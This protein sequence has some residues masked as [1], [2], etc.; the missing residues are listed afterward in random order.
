M[1]TNSPIKCSTCSR[2]ILRI[3]AMATPTRWTSFGPRWRSTWAASVSPSDSSRIAALSTLLNLVAV[4]L[5]LIGVNPLFHNLGYAARVFGDQALDGVQ[6]C[7]IPLTRA[8][9]EDA[10]RT[11]QAHT[12]LSQITTQCAHFTQLN[13]AITAVTLA[14]AAIGDVIEDRAQHTKYQDENKQHAEDLLDH[15]SEPRLCVERDINHLFAQFGGERRI[16][17]ADAVTPTGVKTYRV[18]YQAG[19]PRQVIAA[20]RHARGF[21]RGCVDFHLIVHYHRYRQPAQAPLLLLGVADRTIQLEVACGLLA[22]V[23]WVRRQHGQ[24]GGRI[25]DLGAIG[26]QQRLPGSN[27][28]R[29]GRRSG[30]RLLR[31][32]AGC[33]R[34]IAQRAGDTLWRQAAG[35]LFV[36]RL[37][38]AQR[39]LIRVKHFRG[40]FH[41]AEIH[42]RRNFGLVATRAQYRLQDVVHALGEQAFH[43][44]AVIEL[45]AGHG[46]LGHFLNIRQQIALLVDHGDLGLVHFRHAAG[47][48]IDD[49][50][51]LTRFQAAPGIQLN[52]YR[53]AGFAL[54]THKHRTLRDGQVY[55]GRFN[56]IQAGNGTRQFTFQAAAI[57]GG[58]HKLA[59]AQALLLVENLKTDAIVF[60]CNA[61]RS[62]AH[63]GARQVA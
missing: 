14:F 26:I 15:I 35:T 30:T 23:L 59:G 42:I 39:R 21:A 31:R 19:K 56:V 44:A 32:G 25:D 63:T 50:H 5:S 58:F 16:D 2:W 43:A 34:L 3:P 12:V 8:W 24:T 18:L 27:R 37:I 41:R 4:R 53:G 1:S 33:R 10:L 38:A 13:I 29:H 22:F 55:A 11:A 62:Q 9:Q 20:P 17:H 36:D 60:R 47:D 45:L 51:H 28:P 49:R 57:A 48:Q 54:I 6:L 7:I 40:G 46:Q 52:Q 61:S